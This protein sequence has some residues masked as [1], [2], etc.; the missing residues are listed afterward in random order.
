MAASKPNS[1]IASRSVTDCAALRLSLSERRRTVPR[2]IESSTVRTMSR[3]PSSAARRSRNAMTSG[4]LWPV[5]M[6]ISGNGKPPGRN[7]FS[8]SRSST[9]ES[10][11]PENSSTGLWHWPATSRRM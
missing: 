2:L 3:S 1:P 8:A 7:A 11:P 6:C 4:K 5:S 10:L 9:A